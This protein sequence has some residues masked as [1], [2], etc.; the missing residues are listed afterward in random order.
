MRFTEQDIAVL[1]YERPTIGHIR[2][3][4][5]RLTMQFHNLTTS[6]LHGYYHET[7]AVFFFF[8]KNEGEL[9]STRLRALAHR[10]NSNFSTYM[11]DDGQKR[12]VVDRG[13]DGDV[14]SEE[15][16]EEGQILVTEQEMNAWVKEVC[17]LIGSPVVSLTV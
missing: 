11:R 14:E 7:D 8:G 10:L 5:S 2:M 13:V 15:W 16:S 12:K 6:A 3:F 9:C 1:G 4:L 17:D